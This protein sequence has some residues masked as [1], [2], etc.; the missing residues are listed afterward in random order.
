MIKN[1]ERWTTN[2]PVGGG[3]GR[4]LT[5]SKPAALFHKT[6]KVSGAGG[7]IA[8]K[9]WAR[10]LQTGVSESLQQESDLY[11][12]FLT[13]HIPTAAAGQSSGT[14]WGSSRFPST[15]YW[16]PLHTGVRGETWGRMTRSLDV[17]PSSLYSEK[18][19]TLPVGRKRNPREQKGQRQSLSPSKREDQSLL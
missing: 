17:Q 19:V 5:W 2:A 15:R 7:T 4:K 9:G 16:N 1:Q 6:H 18:A 8:W 11:I 10:P 12:P 13:W 14:C 3:R